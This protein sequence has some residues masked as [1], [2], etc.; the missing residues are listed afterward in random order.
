MNNDY[1]LSMDSDLCHVHSSNKCLNSN[2][3]SNAFIFSRVTTP[4]FKAF[5]N[6]SGKLKWSTATTNRYDAL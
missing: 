2:V 3:N 5:T 1:N 4:R 6:N